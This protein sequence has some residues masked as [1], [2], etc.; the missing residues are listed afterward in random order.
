MIGSGKGLTVG[1]GGSSSG[2]SGGGVSIPYYN[3]NFELLYKKVVT[4]GTTGTVTTQ[5]LTA[6]P[7]DIVNVGS[8]TDPATGD[9]TVTTIV[10]PKGED[11]IGHR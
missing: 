8:E 7:N 2:G 10:G 4:D 1:Y 3:Q 6:A 11:S 5:Y 9:V